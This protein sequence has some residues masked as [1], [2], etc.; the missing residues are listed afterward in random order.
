VVGLGGELPNYLAEAMVWA[1]AVRN[2]MAHNGSRVDTCPV[3]S[4]PGEQVPC[5]RACKDPDCRRSFECCAVG[6][7]GRAVHRLVAWA[8]CPG[9]VPAA[10]SEI[11]LVS[12]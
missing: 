1:N 2:I 3:Q 8:A 12:D 10:V 4:K 11:G 5:L 7:E 6:V 9:G